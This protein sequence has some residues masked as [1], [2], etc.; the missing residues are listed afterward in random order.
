MSTQEE[1]ESDVFLRPRRLSLSSIYGDVDRFHGG[2]CALMRPHDLL[3][4]QG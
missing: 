1:E 3:A 4:Y 2:D